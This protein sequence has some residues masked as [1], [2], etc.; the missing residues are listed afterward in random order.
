MKLILGLFL[1]A[2]LNTL[3][4]ADAPSPL[5]DVLTVSGAEAAD[6]AKSLPGEYADAGDPGG[7]ISQKTK[8]FKSTADLTEI[9]CTQTYMSGALKSE[10]CTMQKSTNGVPFNPTLHR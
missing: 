4:L 7:F 2:G 9:V 3:A 8:S 10:F 5:A 6:L 1:I